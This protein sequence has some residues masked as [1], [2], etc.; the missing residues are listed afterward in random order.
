[1]LKRSKRYYR[2]VHGYLTAK[3]VSRILLCA[4]N[5]FSQFVQAGQLPKPSHHFEDQR[6][7]YYFHK[8][9]P[10]IEAKYEQI[11]KKP[12]E[13]IHLGQMARILK[14]PI[15]LI[16]TWMNA[17]KI[18]APDI[19]KG[20]KLYYQRSDIEILKKQIA[21]VKSKENYWK[22]HWDYLA[23][24]G[25]Y[26]QQALA[27]HLKIPSITLAYWKANKGLPPPTHKIGS[28]MLYTKE[29]VEKIKKH[30]LENNYKKQKR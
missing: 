13:L 6:K 11:K 8:D 19:P 10:A 26:S 25:Y 7:L 17:M 22:H 23:S 5:E 2:L 15:S 30:M 3:D 27:R 16:R 12:I 20:K 29:D 18:K 21:N 1:M 24:Q 4:Q 9:L 14:Y 28:L